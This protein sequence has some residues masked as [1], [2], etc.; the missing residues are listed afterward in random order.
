MKAKDQMA[1]GDGFDKNV[2]EKMP[3]IKK[4]EE[5]PSFDVETER[6]PLKE[7]VWDT[8][9]EVRATEK[10]ATER[11]II[12]QPPGESAESEQPLD[13]LKLIEDLHAQVLASGRIKRA[14]E[15]D[16]GS[17]QKTIHQLAQDNR[18]L[19]AQ[20][21][22]MS[23]QIQRVN[24]IRTESIYL[25]EENEDALEKIRELQEELRSVNEAL[26]TATRER[27]EAL[28][29][30]RDLESRVEQNE[31]LRIKERMKEREASHFSEENREIR[32]RL[33]QALAR[34]AD[35]EKRY[36]TL[37]RSFEEV[38]ESLSLLRESYKA[39]YYNLSE[40]TE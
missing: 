26:A 29:R 38:K 36:E 14:L 1:V 4:L 2:A 17:S 23:K 39:S 6:R 21:E 27:E 33:E 40:N 28:S 35:L 7:D 15:M 24:E 13:V 9:Q 20:R 25:K 30:T 31:L 18:E 11:R 10:P 19:R 34:N 8:H 3:K 12:F 37:R 5:A 22:E 32:S 16:L